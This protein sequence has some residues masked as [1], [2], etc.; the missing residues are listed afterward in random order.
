MIEST[1]FTFLPRIISAVFGLFVV[2]FI[3]CS[4]HIDFPQSHKTITTTKII[5]ITAS[6]PSHHH[7]HLFC[8][9]K[10]VCKSICKILYIYRN[11]YTQV[12]FIS[13]YNFLGQRRLWFYLFLFFSYFLL[14]T[15][16]KS[17]QRKEKRKTYYHLHAGV[18]CPCP[19]FLIWFSLKRYIFLLRLLSVGMYVNVWVCV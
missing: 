15:L 6:S 19:Y 11:L 1:C 3:F 2:L 7:Y 4:V 13:T 9:C 8:L 17:S 18:A 14:L 12:E 10:C 5:R 16:F